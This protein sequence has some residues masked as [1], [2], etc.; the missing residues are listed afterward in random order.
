MNFVGMCSVDLWFDLD[1]VGF[2]VL[3]VILINFS[4]SVRLILALAI[5]EATLVHLGL[6][7]VQFFVLNDALSEV[8]SVVEQILNRNRVEPLA[9][10]HIA[11]EKTT[12][13][14]DSQSDT[15]ACQL[16]AS[17]LIGSA[18]CGSGVPTI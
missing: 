11:S 18:L 3:V 15:K 14:S 17:L 8:V 4:L 7:D 6:Q 13:D 9:R 1:K 2:F 12:K 10:G 5:R 16:I